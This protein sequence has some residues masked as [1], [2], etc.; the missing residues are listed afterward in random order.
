MP[1][2]PTIE[3]MS[4]GFRPSDQAVSPV[5]GAILMVSITVTLAAVVFV[6]VKGIG[7]PPPESAHLGFTY[8]EVGDRMT[9]VDGGGKVD[10]ASLRMQMSVPG[11]YGLG[12]TASIA[13]PVLGPAGAQL[14]AIPGTSLQAADAVAFC[15]NAPATHVTVLVIDRLT[16]TVI[17][18]HVFDSVASCS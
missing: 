15:A 17:A 9:L 11:H 12:Q 4:P 18:Q 2:A 10:L 5:L 1:D 7:T 13:S 16:E 8:D 6:V 14:S 3:I